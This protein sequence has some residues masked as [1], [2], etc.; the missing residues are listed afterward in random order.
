MTSS[1]PLAAALAGASPTPDAVADAVRRATARALDE[2]AVDLTY[3]QLDS[4]LGTLVAAQ[5]EQGLVRL[6]YQEFNGGL[7]AVLDGLATRVSPRIVEAPG[8][9]FDSLRRQLDEYFEGGRRDF[10]VPLDWSLSRGFTQRILHAIAAIPF[11]ATATYRDVAEKAGNAKAVRAA[12]NA[13]SANPL[14]I[15]VP[16]HRVLRTGGALG[17]YTGGVE[18]KQILLDLEGA[19]VK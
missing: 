12:G 1:D 16:C 10:D 14:P 7:D 19:A 18:K 2:G 3:A 11:G 5:T 8:G 4:P 6:A 9:G 15:V 13:C 17:G